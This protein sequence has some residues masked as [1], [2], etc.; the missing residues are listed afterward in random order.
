MPTHILYYLGTIALV[1][2]VYS[3]SNF[4][5]KP[6]KVKLLIRIIAS[7]NLVYCLFSGL[8]VARILS[9]LSTLDLVYFLGEILIVSVLAMIELK[10][11]AS[12]D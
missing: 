1:F 2:A 4:F 8:I 9:R 10:V 11:A 7:A 3:L 12:I 5:L 6:S